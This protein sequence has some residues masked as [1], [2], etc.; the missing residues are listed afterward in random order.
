MRGQATRIQ[1]VPKICI[2]IKNDCKR[3]VLLEFYGFKCVK[4]F[5]NNSLLFF[6]QHFDYILNNCK[7]PMTKMFM[8]FANSTTEQNNDSQT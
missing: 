5:T 7:Q 2:H 1:G 6:S 8:F 3:R 4:I